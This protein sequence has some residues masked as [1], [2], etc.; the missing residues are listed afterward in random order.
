[1]LSDLNRAS[2]R[3]LFANHTGREKEKPMYDIKTYMPILAFCIKG[4]T[5]TSKSFKSIIIMVLLFDSIHS[6]LSD[7]AGINV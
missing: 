3:P 7:S 2:G 1:M 4:L 6:F 5:T